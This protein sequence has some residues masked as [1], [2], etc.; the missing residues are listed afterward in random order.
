[1]KGFPFRAKW[2]PCRLERHL[3]CSKVFHRTT[4]RDCDPCRVANSNIFSR[5]SWETRF[6]ICCQVRHRNLALTHPHHQRRR[7]PW[8]FKTV[9]W[10][11]HARDA[12]WDFVYLAL[13]HYFW[14]KSTAL[15]RLTMLLSTFR[16]SV[17]AA[18]L[19]RRGNWNPAWVSSSC[20]RNGLLDSECLKL[21]GLIGIARELD[22]SK[23]TSE[24]SRFEPIL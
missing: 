22:T 18:L 20:H 5:Q 15:W 24:F 1:M 2:L 17:M 4:T 8:G 14:E 23:L 21:Y 13:H 9:W 19:T 3:K 6:E 7:K 16:E 10:T 12:V 11:L